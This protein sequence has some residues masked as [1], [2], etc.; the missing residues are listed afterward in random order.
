[1][2]IDIDGF[3]HV[4]ITAPAELE[5]EVIAWYAEVMGLERVAKP[6]GT[7]AQGGWFQ[8]GSQQLHV[9]ID[10]HNPPK[11]AHFCLVVSE[12][13]GAIE[14]LREAGCHI[15]Q[16]AAIP[17]RKRF[18]TRDPAGNRIEITAYD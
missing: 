13:D 15:E 1:V 4:A 17:G 11:D 7:R 3:D 5:G 9:L 2:S 14:T 8:L 10:E 18:Y 12:I 16:A 6:D